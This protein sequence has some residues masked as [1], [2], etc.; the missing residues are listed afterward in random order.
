MENKIR[1]HLAAQYV[2]MFTPQQIQK[3]IDN[4]VRDNQSDY[5]VQK[6]APFA[7]PGFKI[8]DVGSGYGS[9]T[10]AGIQNGYDC[11]GIEIA[12]FEHQISKERAIDANIDPSVF[13][14]G[15]AL[16]LPYPNE[17]F[18]IVTF[19]NVLEHINDHK[20]AIK[21]AN[22]VLKPGGKIFIIAPNYFAF[23]NEAHY[24]IPWVPLFP[25]PLARI[26]LRLLKR[27]TKFLDECIFYITSF[28]LKKFLKSI[29]LKV[30]T[31]VA[32]KIKMDYKFKSSRINVL[33]SYIKRFK[34]IKL[35]AN[36]YLSYKTQPF[37][38]SIDI[39]VQK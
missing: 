12:D 18:D 20:T 34:A 23:R 33:V 38:H 37:V 32:E 13:T 35:F 29:D 26:Y 7:K 27:Q 2:G 19:W 21:E 4:Y 17:T 3:H 24:L 36:L 6:I 15:S 30:T 39:V 16:E 1:T 31:D 11:H 28:G 14:H 22:R 25:R 8:L 5:L 10:I 9:F